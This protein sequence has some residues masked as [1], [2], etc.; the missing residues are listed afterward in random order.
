MVGSFWCLCAGAAGEVIAGWDKGIA[1]MKIGETCILEVSPENGYG[2]AGAPPTIPPNATLNFEVELL[3]FGPKPK[4]PW[5]M[6][7][8]ERLAAAEE[9]KQEGNRCVT[10]G[11]ASLALDCYEQSLA[12]MSGIE[13]GGPVY[14]GEEADHEA[15]QKAINALLSSVNNNMAMLLL[16]QQRWQEAADR[17]TKALAADSSNA[18]AL[19]RRGTARLNLGNIDAA[20][21]DLTAA[22]K[23]APSD[24]AIRAEL[25]KVNKIMAEAK[26]KEKKAFGGAFL[27]KGLS[28]YDDREGVPVDV[29]QAINKGTVKLPQVFMDISIGGKPLGRIV[30]RLFTH[31]VPKTA[32]NFLALCKGDKTSVSGSGR[33]LH[34]KGSTFHRIIPNFMCQGGDFENGNGTG[35]E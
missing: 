2:L 18:K 21:A 30:F 14:E 26:E 25:E 20:K 12:F 16:K 31:A 24:A 5:E 19:F 8:K 11:D 29:W 13:E 15:N 4:E 22:L 32:A 9:K 27:K 33:K 28:L 10:K 23:L 3:G 1:T 35:G 34:Y 17:A 7:T 6:S